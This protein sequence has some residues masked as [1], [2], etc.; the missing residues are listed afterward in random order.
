VGV[1]KVGGK[2]ALLVVG[3]A[4]L[5]I[6][7]VTE[8]GVMQR[9]D[10]LSDRER[11]LYERLGPVFDEER[12]RIVK[13]LANKE[14]KELFG[15]TEFELRDRVHALGAR[16]LEAAADERPKKGLPEC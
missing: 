1:S 2:Y 3:G 12:L 5:P 11:A 6:F 8:V 7:T 4:I 13:L 15:R 16:T 9:V 10:E 14:D